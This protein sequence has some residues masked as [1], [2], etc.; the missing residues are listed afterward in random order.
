VAVV[1]EPYIFQ[2]VGY[3]NSGKTTFVKKVTEQLS[4][5][6]Y[7][8]ATIKHHGHGGKPDMVEN[9]D[10]SEH[11]LAGAF[12]SLV[13]GDGRLILQGEKQEWTIT[14]Q[15]DILRQL[16]PDFIIIEGHKSEDYPKAV[17]LRTLEDEGLLY[18]L[19]NIQT[20]F[21]WD[22]NIAKLQEL[23]PTLPFFDIQDLAGIDW[24]C[25]LLVDKINLS[26]I[27]DL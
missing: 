27:N 22:K 13:E 7:S 12:A 9:K 8:I 5:R 4:A 17:I 24:V 3:Q 15:T 23:F 21:Y 16:Y 1:K 26:Q 25:T 19:S 18:K 6:N 11:I 2:V 14:E 20:V 10:S